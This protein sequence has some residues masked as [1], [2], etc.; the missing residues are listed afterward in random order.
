MRLESSCWSFEFRDWYLAFCSVL[1]L[2]SLCTLTTVST[3]WRLPISAALSKE[4]PFFNK[5]RVKFWVVK[6]TG[7]AVV[8][9]FDWGLCVKFAGSPC[10][11]V[12]F[13]QVGRLI[14]DS[15]L[16][17]C[18]CMLS[19]AGLVTCPGWTPC[20]DSWDRFQFSPVVHCDTGQHE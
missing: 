4:S 18:M 6:Y 3:L 5:G 7:G 8:I 1:Y 17:V 10:A 9:R 19:C 12:G 16:V 20:V 15:K 14:G 13:L 11:C 2:M